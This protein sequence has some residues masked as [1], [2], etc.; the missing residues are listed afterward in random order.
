MALCEFENEYD[1]AIDFSH[2]DSNGY[3][4]P[5]G[6]QYIVNAVADKHLF[7]YDVAYET[8]I[9]LGISWVI[10]SLTIDIVNPVRDRKK[11]LIG[12]TWY[13]QRKGIFFRRE[14]SVQDEDGVHI[15]NC[16][17]Y[18]T[19]LNLETRSIFRS[20]ELPFKL[21][22][23]TEKFLIEAKPTFKEKYEYTLCEKRVVKRS[24]LDMLGH[25]NNGRYSEF[26][27]DALTDEEASLARL[28][29]FEI[30]F[31]SEL[32][33]SE[34]FSIHKSITDDKITVMGYNENLDK[35]AFYGVF[36]YK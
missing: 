1:I 9:K 33:L 17:M 10:L 20:R 19:L 24:Y 23:P 35:P 18:S 21:M 22:E 15:L 11:R 8:L 14:M 16:T 12:K 3:L 27:Y 31:V 30:Y 25:V 34:E 29:R 28:S 32:K 26:C 36:W 7:K 2:F 6:Y 13:S 4:T 5:T